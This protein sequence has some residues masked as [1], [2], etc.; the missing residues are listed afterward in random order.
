MTTSHNSHGAI[1]Q[2]WS[3]CHWLIS[4]C[5]RSSRLIYILAF[6]RISSFLKAREQPIFCVYPIVFICSSTGE[7]LGCSY[8]YSY[9]KHCCSEHVS[10]DISSS[11]CFQFFWINAWND[12]SSACD[13][14]RSLHPVL[15][16]G[17]TYVH[18]SV[19]EACHVPTPPI[20][21]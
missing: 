3:L 21:P 1:M 17:C 9:C 11:S 10:A 12:R 20:G 13:L 5:I 7:H 8:V 14:P 19:H 4:L 18:T 16:R 6:C 2:C 15:H